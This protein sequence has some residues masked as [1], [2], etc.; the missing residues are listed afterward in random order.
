MLNWD[1]ISLNDKDK[2]RLS[3]I[4]HG[5]QSS[6]GCYI[7]Y[8]DF[9]PKPT[10]ENEINRFK[11]LI[12]MNFKGIFQIIRTGDYLVPIISNQ[13]AADFSNMNIDGSS[14]ALACVILFF[15]LEHDH[16]PTLQNLQKLLQ[17]TP[18]INKIKKILT[19]L[20]DLRWLKLE[21]IGNIEYYNPTNVMFACISIETLKRVYNSIYQDVDERPKLLRFL[22]P[23]Y[24]RVQKDLGLSIDI[25]KKNEEIIKKEVNDE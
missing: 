25:E 21:K 14:I 12:N 10:R 9:G 17:G 6:P 4:L 3:L 15:K 1:K 13:G 11:K 16:G 24:L 5:S 2:R 7:N 23:D 20:T 18:I 22:S 19:I 8:L